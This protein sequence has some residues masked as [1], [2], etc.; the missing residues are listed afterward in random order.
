MTKRALCPG[1]FDPVTNGHLDIIERARSHF[2]E[3]IVAVMHNPDKH[4]RFAVDHRIQLLRESLIERRGV[5]V[6]AFSGV[7]LVDVC[8]DLGA[9]TIVKGIRGSADYEYELP[10][11]RMNRALAGVETIFL[12]SDPRWDHVSSSLVTE[13]AA[14][15]GDVSEFV[16]SLVWDA[17]RS[18]A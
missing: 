5:R 11:A 16:P 9:A 18:Q 15:G 14:Y 8:A 12:P 4:G 10:M 17:L 13:V 7:L 3:V 1:S 2:D 6:E